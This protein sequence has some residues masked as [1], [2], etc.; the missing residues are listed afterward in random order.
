[1]LEDLK[2]IS[3]PLPVNGSRG[4]HRLS[5]CISPKGSRGAYF[6]KVVLVAPK[7]VC[8]QPQRLEKKRETLHPPPVSELAS[9]GE[10][11][12]LTEEGLHHTLPKGKPPLKRI[13]T[14]VCGKVGIPKKTS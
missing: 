3:C 1:M 14:G 11:Q 5:E 13:S 9:R 7:P 8:D 4:P 2:Y 12:Q 6:I 10:K